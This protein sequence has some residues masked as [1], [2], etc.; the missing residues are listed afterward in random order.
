VYWS[1]RNQILI[2]LIAIQ[3]LAVCAIT[4]TTA[5]LTARR[6]ER[7]VI[8]RLKGVIETL[9]HASF[10]YTRSVLTKMS[11]L[12]GAEFVAYSRDGRVSETSFAR[13]R[14]KPPTLGAIPL[15]A[16]V[17]RLGQAP[18]VNLDGVR[19]LAVSLV[20][21]EGSQ[22]SPLMVLYPLTVWQETRREA[23]TPPLLLGLGALLGMVAV[24]GWIAQ[25]ISRRIRFVRQQV[26]CIA[27]GNFETIDADRHRD[28][29]GDLAE[30]I[31]SMCLQLRKMSRTI[32]HAER[33]KV[34]AQLA[35]GLAHQ[36]RNALTGARM[37][38]QL[39]A[40]RCQAAN[41]DQSL[42]VA[43]RQLTMIEEQV[44]GLLSLGHVETRG[45]VACNVQRLF[46][47]VALMVYPGCEHAKVDFRVEATEP[48]LEAWADEEGLRAVVLNLALN[49]IDA[50]GP[51]GSVR[52][53][54]NPQGDSVAIEVCDSGPGPSPEIAESLFEPFT[55][56]KPEGI[57]I[58]LA[59]ARQ[60]AEQN[61][62][63]L[64]WTRSDGET[65][66]S[67]LLPRPG[68]SA[69]TKESK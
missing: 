51:G 38:V 18:T 9:G 60:I 66:F 65:C 23:V 61:G 4:T 31:N 55:S 32:R 25:C 62:G 40:R 63:G 39:H 29:I 44:K 8:D 58:G 33:T 14:D 1:I 59:F 47:D 52:L 30:S 43:L 46:A 68:D 12:S 6:S 19:Y 11:G 10:P 5:L 42:V 17:D 37:S 45:P 50:A 28:E 22:A 35:A 3:C 2:P 36:L 13:L 41:A 49:A 21:S 54:A 69:L 7:Q 15:V 67:L 16:H 27:A 64:D 56:S 48:T 34:L 20:P 57:G 24:T 53:K 26:A